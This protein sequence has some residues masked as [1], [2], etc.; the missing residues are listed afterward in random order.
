MTDEGRDFFSSVG[1]RQNHD[2]RLFPRADGGPL[3]TS[4]QF[5]PM[6]DACKAAKITPAIGFHILRHT[7]AARLAMKGVPLPVIAEQ[8]WPRGHQDHEPALRASC[9]P[10]MSVTPFR[11]AFGELGI[12]RES[13]VVP[14]HASQT[15]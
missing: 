3:G 9:N 8:T 15:L 10:A 1:R 13:V 5:R 6:K 11:A 7:Y 12:A 14:L 4:S 2:A